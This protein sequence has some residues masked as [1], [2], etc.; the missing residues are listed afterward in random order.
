MALIMFHIESRG[1]IRGP[2]GGLLLGVPVGQG[3]GFV[4]VEISAADISQRDVR[5]L[6]DAVAADRATRL[7]CVGGHR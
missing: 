7:G 4:A 6:A 3:W 1:W 2:E 5:H